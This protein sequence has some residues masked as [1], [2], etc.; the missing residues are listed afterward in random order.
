MLNKRKEKAFNKEIYL[1][2]ER[3]EDGKMVYL[4]VPSWDCGWYWGF[5]YLETYTNNQN[6]QLAKD[7][8]SHSHFDTDILKGNSYPFNNF[9]N[10]FNDTTLTDDEIWKLCDYMRSF[11]TLKSAATLFGSGNSH[12]TERATIK[13]LHDEGIANIINHQKLP[14]LFENIINLLKPNDE[15]KPCK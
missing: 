3:K 8:Y 15:V 10:Y 2:G 9:K 13:T 7:I 11:Y 6:P 1:L 12:Q 14:L 5:G 4:E